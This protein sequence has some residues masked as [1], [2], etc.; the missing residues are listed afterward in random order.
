MTNYNESRIYKIW[1]NLNG[2]DEIYIGSS[3]RFVGRCKLHES[4]CNNINSPRYGYKLYQYIRNNGGF[5]NFTIDVLEKYPCK[6]KTELHIREEYWKNELN[7][8]LN[9]NKAHRTE[10]DVKQYQKEY[11]KE[12]QKQEKC[13]HYLKQIITC[14]K[15]GKKHDRRNTTNHQRTKYCQ[16]Y[17]STSS[18]SS[19]ESDIN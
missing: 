10:Q 1:C 14:S 8:T 9:T 7:P 11:H 15:C 3:A 16:N 19:T 2:I 18:E 6:N 12:Y 5:E 17:K 13:K 4:D